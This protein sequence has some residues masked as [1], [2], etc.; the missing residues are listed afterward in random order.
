M[1]I[2]LKEVEIYELIEEL[3]SRNVRVD[4]PLY[5]HPLVNSYPK[6]S[7]L[8]IEQYLNE[9]TTKSA[10]EKLHSNFPATFLD[11]IENHIIIG[12]DIDD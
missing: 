7:K 3:K 2:N 8:I 9:E 11:V 4:H 6:I 10:L 12:Y 5:S 1:M